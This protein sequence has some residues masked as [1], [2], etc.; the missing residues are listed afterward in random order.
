MKKILMVD[1]SKC[2][3]CRTCEMACSLRHE[4][5]CSPL[6]SRIRIVKF[7][8]RG[9]NYPHVCSQCAKP[10][11]LSACPQGALQLNTATGAVVID[12]DLCTGCRLCITACPQGQIAM[13]PEKHV[14]FKCDLCGG[15]PVCAKYCP[16]GAVRFTEVDEFLMAK[17]RE[18]TVRQ[19]HVS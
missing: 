7:E 13:H 4:K 5:V 18:L 3:G 1:P 14:S 2:T 6:L 12:E 9:E 15:D 10:Q 16:S 19:R 11:C 8:S 17:R